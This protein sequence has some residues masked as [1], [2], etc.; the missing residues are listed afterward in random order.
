MIRVGGGDTLQERYILYDRRT[1]VKRS[2]FS[3]FSME[4]QQMT[5]KIGKSSSSNINIL[6]RD[7]KESIKTIAGF[8]QI[9][10]AEW[11]GS[12]RGLLYFVTSLIAAL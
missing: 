1:G 9:Q 7:M 11:G 10:G 3:S 5:L 4:G 6:F 2:K 8:T 12:V